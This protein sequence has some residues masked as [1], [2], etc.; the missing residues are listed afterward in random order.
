MD[1]EL[2]IK[3]NTL[4]IQTF[5]RKRDLKRKGPNRWDILE[6][7]K[8]QLGYCQHSER[9]QFNYLLQLLVSVLKREQVEHVKRVLI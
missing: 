9:K 1:I 8:T 7:L 2:Y 4:Y 6:E 5:W 3:L